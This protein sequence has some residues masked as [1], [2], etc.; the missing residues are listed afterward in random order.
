MKRKT[1][2]LQSNKV[3]YYL[4]IALFVMLSNSV[5]SQG[6]AVNTTGA[7][8]DPSAV[9]DASSNT[10]GLLIPRMTTAERNAIVNPA[11]G[12]QIYNTTTKCLEIYITPMWQSVY[13]GCNPPVA[14]TAGT[15]SST[16]TEI[17]WNWSSVNGATGY[18]YNTVNDYQSAI[19]NGNI[20]SYTQAGLTCNTACTLY[21]WAYSACG[22]STAT[23]LNQ[24]TSACQF[25]CGTSSVTFTYNGASAT[26]GSVNGGYNSGQYCWLDR[27]LGATAV[28]TAIN[29]VDGYG[30]LFQ[31]GRL[32]D[33]HQTR[34]SGTTSTLSSND[35]PG[36]ANFILAP[37]SPYDWRNPQNAALWQGASGTNNPCPAGWRLPTETEFNNERTSWS[38][39]NNSGAIASPLKL[40]AA[41]YRYTSFGFGTLGNVGSF[42]YYWCSAVSVT[43]VQYLRFHSSDAEMGNDYRA[44]GMSVRCIKDY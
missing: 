31:W 23:S 36:H 5:F 44:T 30:D 16:A 22:N 33:G 15:H 43:Y 9:F 18:K 17:I 42:G 39:N 27:N 10:Q 38:Q 3:A 40:P 25:I 8:A 19:D 41:G 29:H 28:A 14:P 1:H 24:T 32:D 34:T 11:E 12:L 4:L 26:Y 7:S 21:V 6:A 20:L 37:N 2:Y 13:C 35:V